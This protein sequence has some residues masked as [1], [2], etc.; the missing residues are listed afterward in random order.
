M[1]LA[2]MVAF[3]LLSPHVS[4]WI[5]RCRRGADAPPRGL[6]RAKSFRLKSYRVRRRGAWAHMVNLR[7]HALFD[8]VVGASSGAVR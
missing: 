3:F 1:L 8:A 7:P 6:T 5:K 2:G 4:S